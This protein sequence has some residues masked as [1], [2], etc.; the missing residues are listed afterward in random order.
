LKYRQTRTF[1]PKDDACNPE[2]KSFIW[3]ARYDTGGAPGALLKGKALLQV[4]TGNIEQIDL[5]AAFTE[6]GKRRTAQLL[7]VPPVSQ[8][9]SILTTP[10][11][12]MELIH[13]RER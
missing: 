11:P 7:G 4:S 2:G 6:K 13:M 5:G 12:V 10:P 1:K 8:G 3:S 9:L